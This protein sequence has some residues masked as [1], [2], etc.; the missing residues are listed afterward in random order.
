M[1]SRT[2]PSARGSLQPAAGAT[3]KRAT[4]II[5]AG[6][7]LLAPAS[8]FALFTDEVEIWASLNA[9]HDSNVLRLSKNLSPES[10]G[11]PRLGD[12]YKT[13][14]AGIAVDVPV[15]L[16]RIQAAYTWQRTRYNAFTNLDFDGHV[17]TLNWAWVVDHRFFG[18]LGGSDSRG[19]ASFSNIQRNAQDLVTTRVAYATGNW[20]ATPDWRA[21]GA[22]NWGKSTHSDPLRSAND[23]ETTGG[24]AGLA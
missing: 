14:K 10:V 17:A 13:F 23:I 20:R 12:T 16:Q 24:E 18:T 2:A 1:P 3:G 5:A 15:S 4:A 9:T 6:L 19:L 21:S 11:A 8:A 7:A 22:L